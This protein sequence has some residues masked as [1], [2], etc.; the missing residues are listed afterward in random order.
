[1]PW[2][3]PAF[4]VFGARAPRAAIEKPSTHARRR[5]SIPSQ[6]LRPAKDQRPRSQEGRAVSV[7]GQVTRI[8]EVRRPLRMGGR[9][10]LGSRAYCRQMISA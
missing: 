9:R 2:L 7:S 6:A 10:N 8:L 3:Q 5:R 4:S 1:M